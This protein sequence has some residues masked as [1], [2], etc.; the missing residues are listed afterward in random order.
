MKNAISI[1]CECSRQN[2]SYKYLHTVFKY[3]S[4]ECVL[5]DSCHYYG[6]GRHQLS[7]ALKSSMKSY[8]LPLGSFQ[9]S[10]QKLS[11]M[12]SVSVQRQALL[13]VFEKSTVDSSLENSG[14]WQQNRQIP[15]KAVFHGL[16]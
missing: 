8:K 6:T 12:R 11:C 14:L 3:D 7:I 1:V 2:L 16:I 9:K 10:N 4:D 5:L 13:F 15:C